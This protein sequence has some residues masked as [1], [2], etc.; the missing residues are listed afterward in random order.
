MPVE[1][2]VLSVDADAV[3]A[4]PVAD[5]EAHELRAALTSEPIGESNEQAPAVSELQ[6]D[7]ASES[8][9]HA[10]AESAPSNVIPLSL[11]RP[12]PARGQTAI[13]LV[14]SRARRGLRSA[15]IAACVAALAGAGAVMLADI[16]ALGAWQAKAAA[17]SRPSFLDQFSVMIKALKSDPTRGQPALPLGTSTMDGYDMSIR[18]RE[19]WHH[20][21]F[22]VT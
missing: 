16:G 9:I 6:I 8:G 4:E 18:Y 2:P 3:G 17:V 12:E 10:T 15:K 5:P 19:A 7:P 21:S 1:A 20:S 11:C 13:P 22:S 14:R